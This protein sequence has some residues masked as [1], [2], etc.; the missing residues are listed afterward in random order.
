MTTSA[1]VTIRASA[2]SKVYGDFV[3]VR[4]LDFEVRKGTVAAFLGPNGAGKSTTMK[5][6]TGYLAPSSGSVE[7]LGK[8]PGAADSR[9]ELARRLG[10]LPDRVCPACG[11]YKGREVVTVERD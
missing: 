10:Y 7:L 6:L 4:D 3:A 5:I 8:N 11:H 1:P 9:L 2:V